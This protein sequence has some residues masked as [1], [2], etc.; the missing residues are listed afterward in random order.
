M[1]ILV[2]TI[3]EIV[4]SF[5]D[6]NA[7]IIDVGIDTTGGF[8]GITGMICFYYIILFIKNKFIKKTTIKI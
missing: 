2:G 4:Q 3:D 6:R 1:I 7:N 8:F 5:S